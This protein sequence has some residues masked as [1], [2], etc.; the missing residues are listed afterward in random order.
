[1]A[2]DWIGWIVVVMRMKINMNNLMQ[3]SITINSTFIAIDDNL[4]SFSFSCSDLD[5]WEANEPL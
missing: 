1:M 2:I 5:D 3:P 4:T